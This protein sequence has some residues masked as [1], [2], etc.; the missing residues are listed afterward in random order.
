MGVNECDRRGCENIMCS[1]L[2]RRH[3]YLCSDCLTELYHTELRF[4]SPSQT[5]KLFM[6]T[7]RGECERMQIPSEFVDSEFRSLDWQEE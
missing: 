4:S 1:H 2:S 3:G 7:E 5:I 6:L